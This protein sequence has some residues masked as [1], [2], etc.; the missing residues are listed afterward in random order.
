MQKSFI[1]AV[2]TVCGECHFIDEDTCEKCPV[3]MTVDEMNK[4]EKDNE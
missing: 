2:D 1:D 3:R 4:E